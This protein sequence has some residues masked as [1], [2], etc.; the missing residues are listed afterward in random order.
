MI[1]NKDLSHFH[2]SCKTH[3]SSGEMHSQISCY[4]TVTKCTNIQVS[5]YLNVGFFVFV[6]RDIWWSKGL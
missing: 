3:V 5:F 4:H 6:E 1:L 2:I